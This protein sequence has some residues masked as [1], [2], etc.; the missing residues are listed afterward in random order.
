[1]STRKT[2]PLNTVIV[3]QPSD[4]P[5]NTST[6]E[7]ELQGNTVYRFDGFVASTSP[8]RLAPTAEG[9]SPMIGGHGVSDGFIYTGGTGAAIR[10]TNAGFFMRNMYAHAP[11]GTMFNVTGDLNDEML[12]ESCSFSDAAGI[13]NIADL[14]TIDG[15]RVPTFKDS[16]FEDFDAG[17]LFDGTV[18]A[19]DKVFV[20]GCPMRSVTAAGV[21][22][23]TFDGTIGPEVVDIVDGYVKDIEADTEI[24]R[25]QTGATPTQAFQ[26]RGMTH[27]DT[28]DVNNILNGE[29]AVT[30]VGYNISDSP[31]LR[32]ST[33]IGE[34][35]LNATTTTTINTAGTYEFVNGAVTVGN[36]TERMQAVDDTVNG[37]L[38]YLGRTNK[39][40]LITA[41]ASFTGANGETY[42]IAIAKNGTIEPTSIIEVE[43]GG[44]NAP[45]SVS[46]SGVE[47]LVTNNTISLKVTNLDNT[48]D[49]TFRDYNFTAVGV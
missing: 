38:E 30:A 1:M 4:L 39:N 13:A 16:N 48:N 40:V 21:T 29:A 5:Y 47:D 23:M 14:G 9:G 25:V 27:D 3:S 2:E 20:A 41:S 11:G 33:I 32:D 15:M 28:V 18:T 10:G 17:I 49:A 24:I 31:P 6:G 45:V 36:E 12:V 26:Y 22:M 35:S 7:H 46:T 8:V 19:P 43:A 44:A 42:A 34:T 37:Q